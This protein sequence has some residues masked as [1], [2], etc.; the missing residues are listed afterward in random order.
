[1]KKPHIF[2]AYTNT[3]SGHKTPAYA[4]AESIENLYPGKYTVTVS[5]FFTDAGLKEFDSFIC[6]A[7]NW[8]LKHPYICRLQISISHMLFPIAHRYL[9]VFQHRVWRTSMAYIHSIQPDIVFTTH[10]FCQTIAV[11]AKKKYKLSYQ[12]IT[13]NPDTFE[14]FPQWDK[15]GDL[16]LVNSSIAERK[17]RLL[18]HRL[19]KILKVPQALRNDFNKQHFNK[20]DLQKKY[21]L[22]PNIFTLFMSDGGQGIG[23]MEPCIRKIMESDLKFNIIAVCGRNSNLYKNLLQLQNSN[24]NIQLLVFSYVDFIA[25]LMHA[26][27]IYVGKGGPASVIEALKTKLPVIITYAVNTAEINTQ[28][29]FRRRGLVWACRKPKKLVKLIEFLQKNPTHLE[30]VKKRI[31]N[32]DFFDNGSDLIANIIIQA[33]HDPEFI[34]NLSQRELPF[35]SQNHSY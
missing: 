1:M 27:D 12:I 17:A 19:N 13:L 24:S 3:G 28:K 4:I 7:W 34:K 10:F 23:S 22:R 33:V 30:K 14:T 31:K 35:S 20:E 15:R 32:S 29:F 2:I 9:P 21:G 11:D 5:N 16:L 18:G 8:M 25:E 26:S 6:R